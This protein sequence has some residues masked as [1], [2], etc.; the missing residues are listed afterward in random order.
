MSGLTPADA[1]EP[2]L[3]G[4]RRMSSVA[5]AAAADRPL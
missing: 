3:A 5:Q 4:L 1:T 2:H